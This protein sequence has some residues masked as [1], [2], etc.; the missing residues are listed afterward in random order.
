MKSPSRLACVVILSTLTACRQGSDSILSVCP[1]DL[2]A[3]ID[4][5]T[6]SLRVGDSVQ[7]QATALA[8][9]GTQLLSTSW[10]FSARDSS[11]VRVRSTTGWVIGL[12]PGVTDVIATSQ[13]SYMVSVLSTVTVTP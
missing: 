5:P 6:V 2:Q 7:L 1:A 3:R 11:N 12:R 9:G 10:S 13:P 4:R 8:C